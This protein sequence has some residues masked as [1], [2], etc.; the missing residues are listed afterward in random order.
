M[1]DR[2]FVRGRH[3]QADQ[4]R[5]RVWCLAVSVLVGVVTAFVLTA[6]RLAQLPEATA[7]MQV[8]PS[9][10]GVALWILLGA[11]PGAVI[12]LLGP[13]PV[14]NVTARGLVVGLLWWT[15]WGLTATPVLLGRAPSWD[16]AAVA[17]AFPDL[18]AGLLHGAATGLLSAVAMAHPVL[19]RLGAVAP[20]P[21]MGRPRIVVVGGGFTGVAVAQRL[22]R[23]SR[24]RTSWEVTL[25]SDTNFLLF[26]P[27][28]PEVAGGAVQAH[29]V[30]AALRAACPRTR[31][32]LGRVDSV[33]LAARRVRLASGDVPFDHI[34]MALGAEPA[35]RDL[36]GI[37]EHCLTLKTLGDAI[38]V[39]E[40]VLR[41]LEHADV[42]PDAHERRRLMTFAVV[43][44]GFAGAE[45]AAELRDLVH[46]VLRFY[47]SLDRA[48]LHVVLVHAG[49]RLLPEIGPE[50]ARLAQAQLE[51]HGVQIRL[52]ARVR[53][54]TSRSLLLEGGPDLAG[55]TMVW[56]AGNRPNSVVGS[57]PVEHAAGGALLVGPTLQV[58]GVENVWAAGDCAA[59]PDGH[60]GR[61][62]P[63]AQHALRE[64]KALADNLAAV[65]AGRP[66]RPFQFATIGMLAALGHRTGVAQIRGWRFS[67]VLA[68]AL[69]RGVYLAKL[70]GMEKRVR[71]ALDWLVE[72]GFP[73]DIV[74]AHGLGAETAVRPDDDRG[75][76]QEPR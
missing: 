7:P 29:H 38:R 60:G 71:V 68:W 17:V 59:V 37:S 20:E 45:L 76:G 74:M 16:A 49:E 6:I 44:G 2:A 9:G 73:R 47:P 69:W 3:A 24:R 66:P 46:S 11:V 23:L 62:P 55:A 70:P 53:G 51:A 30:G 33:D 22:E 8:A 34:V 64:G 72:V 48:D 18:V 21:V 50:L 5:R 28:L 65:L 40:H 10:S 75:A 39:R 56:T 31:L 43:G 61:L 25:I 36:P 15:A 14:A 67:G 19:S 13:A 42:E 27:M 63:T 32:V 12:G 4:A 58:V 35:F 1:A 54:A 41:Q 57:L 52:G 26:T